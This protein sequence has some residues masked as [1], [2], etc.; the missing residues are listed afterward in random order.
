MNGILCKALKA[1]KIY[2]N[3]PTNTM[4][5]KKSLKKLRINLAEFVIARNWEQFHSP[6]NLAMA[7]SVEAAEL[8]EIFQW[9]ESSESRTVDSATRDHIEEEIGDVMIYLTMLADKFDLDPI[10]AAHKKMV[11]NAVKYPVNP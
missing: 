4:T 10:E 7:L 6:K 5:K 3:P 2:Q 1:E 11:L 9:M 8:T